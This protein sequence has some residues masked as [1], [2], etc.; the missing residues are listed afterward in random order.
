MTRGIDAGTGAGGLSFWFKK[1]SPATLRDALPRSDCVQPAL[2]SAATG[3]VGRVGVLPARRD[4][5]LRAN[6]GR[7]V[8][9]DSG[10]R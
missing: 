5:D 3:Q 7:Q 6:A 1:L 2:T 9:A 10:N 4:V 8:T